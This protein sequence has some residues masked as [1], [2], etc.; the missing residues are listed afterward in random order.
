MN[1]FA[2]LKA[3][4]DKEKAARFEA[5]I[6]ADILTR[7]VKD[8]K[9]SADKYATQIHTLEDKINHLEGN[10]LD[11]LKEVRAL[12]LILECTT[13]ARDDYQNQVSHLTKK[14]E[15]KFLGFVEMFFLFSYIFN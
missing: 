7:V 1:A 5:Q 9:I 12:E 10:V 11:G 15:S 13:R 14:L 4:L 3:E 8:L 2:N 6:E